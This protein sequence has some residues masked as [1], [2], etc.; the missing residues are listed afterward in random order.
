MQFSYTE[1]MSKKGK[2]KALFNQAV[3]TGLVAESSTSSKMTTEVSA[4]VGCKIDIF[5][6]DL[7]AKVGTEVANAFRDVSTSTHTET[8]QMEADPEN[9]WF[10]YQSTVTVWTTDNAKF[11]FGGPLRSFN[12][13]QHLIEVMDFDVTD[14]P[15]PIHCFRKNEMAYY[16]HAKDPWWHKMPG[17]GWKQEHFIPF[18][19]WLNEQPGTVEIHCF[20]KGEMAYLCHRGWAG[21]DHMEGW[22][23]KFERPLF[24]AYPPEDSPKSAIEVQEWRK[25]EIAYYNGGEFPDASMSSWGWSHDRHAFSCPP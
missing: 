9:D 21:Y 23:W 22:G 17:W 19:A 13:A 2:G 15:V 10:L 12:T 18:K 7:S 1:K 16:I 5:S 14:L 24:W 25:K 11:T 8:M 20:R 4:S 6:A 3:T